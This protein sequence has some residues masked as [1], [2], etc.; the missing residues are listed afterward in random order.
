MSL[1]VAFDVMC[2]REAHVASGEVT[3]KWSLLR[4]DADVSHQMMTTPELPVTTVPVTVKGPFVCV[5]E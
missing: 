5:E 1:V 2:F 3:G 4:M